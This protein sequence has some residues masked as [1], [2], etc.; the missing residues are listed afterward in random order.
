M[1]DEHE[2]VIISRYCPTCKAQIN[3]WKLERDEGR[4]I[5]RCID[6]G[7]TQL[8][9]LRETGRQVAIV[10]SGCGSNR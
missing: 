2:T 1:S 6:C 3:S 10:S 9:E 4:L 5:E 8:I 7:S